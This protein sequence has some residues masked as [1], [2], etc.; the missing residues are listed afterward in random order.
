MNV[1]ILVLASS[2]CTALFFVL[3][4]KILRSRE[5]S[6]SFTSLAVIGVTH[7]VAGVLAVPL[8]FWTPAVQTTALPFALSSFWVFLIFL[9][10]LLHLLAKFFHFRALH[11][12]DVALVSPY[13]ALTP[14]FT[15]F[16]GWIFLNEWPSRQALLGI[17][18]VATS[19][20][21]L[22]T[23]LSWARLRAMFRGHNA[24]GLL[25][26]GAFF[27]LLSSVPPAFKVVFQKQAILLS[28]PIV[29]SVLILVLTGVAAL[30]IT[31][32]IEGKGWIEEFSPL[33]LPLAIVSVFLTLNTVFF[34]V[35]LQ[36]GVAAN[37]SA[38]AR[39]SIVLQA[40]L[41]YFIVGQRDNLWGRLFWSVLV[42]IGAVIITLA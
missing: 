39:I 5:S 16:V 21:G 1:F 6:Y 29:F 30:I 36:H 22:H 25:R 19:I 33:F 8:L 38:M 41:A 4:A 40:V 27:A 12:A 37:I 7:L 14:V 24:S 20:L 11:L 10:V 28:N 3:S 35:A 23:N 2:V 34:S 15:V 32:A 13:A 9:N 17:F 42:F 18:L 26:N 31:T